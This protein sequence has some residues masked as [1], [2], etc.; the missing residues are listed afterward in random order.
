M[1]LIRPVN[2][3]RFVG[4]A[5]AAAFA[6]PL[7]RAQSGKVLKSIPST[8]ETLPAIGMGT[9]LTIDVGANKALRAQRMDVLKAFFEMGGAV[10]D[11]SPMYRRRLA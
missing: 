11:C 1:K 8:G 6:P 5:S 3:R 7:A 4:L 2:R 9:W 10:I